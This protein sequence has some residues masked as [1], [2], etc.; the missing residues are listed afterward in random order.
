[1]LALFRWWKW[2]N[3]SDKGWG[4]ESYTDAL[5]RSGAWLAVR[6]KGQGKE[7]RKPPDS[8]QVCLVVV[9]EK[10]NSR[11]GA[12]VVQTP[13]HI[14]ETTPHAFPSLHLPMIVSLFVR[15]VNIYL[16]LHIGSMRLSLWLLCAL[17]ASKAHSRCLIKILWMNKGLNAESFYSLL[18]M[19]LIQSIKSAPFATV[20][21]EMVKTGADWLLH[22]VGASV[23][24][25]KS[26]DKQRQQ[27]KLK[28]QLL[29]R[30][31]VS[32]F[33]PSILTRHV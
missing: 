9:V 13:Y 8:W 3:K 32:R 1:M 7:A 16:L 2:L 29:H 28:M 11:E 23:D 19:A 26:A 22:R 17:A 31:S 21:S 25:P 18:L 24:L 14:L 10:G 6:G 15:L 4:E 33:F 5:G 27:E 30:W 20:N 12:D